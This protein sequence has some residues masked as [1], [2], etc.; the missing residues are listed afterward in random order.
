M[1]RSPV[2]HRLSSTTQCIPAWFTR[3]WTEVTYAFILLCKTRRDN[4]SSYIYNP[5]QTKHSL[6]S[7]Q[8][9]FLH[10]PKFVNLR[11]RKK[12]EFDREKTPT[13]EPEHV[14][15]VN[16]PQKLVFISHRCG[17]I[18]WSHLRRTAHRQ[19]SRPPPPPP[20]HT[21]QAGRESKETQQIRV[22]PNGP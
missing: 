3:P 13:T 21:T 15:P 4:Y 16:Y 10:F 20:T 17:L 14:W 9:I 12:L 22:H 8:W 5:I 19:S 1:T 11:D 2:K 7:A 18:R 6:S